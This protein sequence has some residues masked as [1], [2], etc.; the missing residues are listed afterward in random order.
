MTNSAPQ[1]RFV[2]A[3]ADKGAAGIPGL[4]KNSREAHPL[5]FDE[6]AVNWA[7]YLLLN[8]KRIPEAIAVFN[9]NVEAYPDSANT[10]DSLSDAY[11]RAGDK[12]QAVFYRRMT[13]DI[14]PLDKKADPATLDSLKQAALV[15]LKTLENK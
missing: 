3:A 14:I 4:H 10:Y 7:G 8:A 2:K 9:L 12:E 11:I 1:V 5:E 6:R 15:K 13:L